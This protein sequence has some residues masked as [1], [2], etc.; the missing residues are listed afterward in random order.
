MEIDTD[1]DLKSEVGHLF[2]C[3]FGEASQL[4]LVERYI[5]AH[6]N[7]MELRDFPDVEL[8]TVRIIVNK[9]LNAAMIEPWLRRKN[10]RR[11]AVSAKLLLLVY[12]A[13]CG[14]ES[15]GALRRGAQGRFQVVFAATR[16][17]LGLLGGFYLK[18][19]HG[20]V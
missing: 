20:L 16:G 5:C 18:L 12:L 19:R 9:R 3:L 8:R 7:I 4:Q 10:R 13:E 14:D 17:V 2:A 6:K 1:I 11:H 15:S